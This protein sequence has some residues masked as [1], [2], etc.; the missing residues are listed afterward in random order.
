M[1]S[2]FGSL[3]T[4]LSARSQPQLRTEH[5]RLSRAQQVPAAVFRLLTTKGSLPLSFTGTDLHMCPLEGLPSVLAG[6]RLAPGLA[7]PAGRGLGLGPLGQ[8]ISFQM[9]TCARPS[10]HLTPC[11]RSLLGNAFSEAA[12]ARNLRREWRFINQ[13]IITERRLS[14]GRLDMPGR[15]GQPGR[16][17]R[18]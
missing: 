1:R 11:G 8:Q 13:K 18:W 2:V 10:D 15:P 3:Q 16:R 12:A 5:K 6:T 17:G 14:A 9:S 4:E 7:P